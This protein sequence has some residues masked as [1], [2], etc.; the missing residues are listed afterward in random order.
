MQYFSGMLDNQAVHLGDT[1]CIQLGYGNYT[2]EGIEA[3][4]GQHVVPSLDNVYKITASPL[5]IIHYE[6]EDC[7]ALSQISTEKYKSL[8][9]EAYSEATFSE[10]LDEYQYP[11]L[12]AEYRSKKLLEALR[13]WIPVYK[14]KEDVATKVDFT[15]IGSAVADTGSRFITTPFVFGAVTFKHTSGCF[16]ADGKAAAKFAYQR[17]A[18]KFPD[19]NLNLSGLESTVAYTKLN[20]EYIFNTEKVKSFEVVK[21]F[22]SLQDAQDFIKGV[23]SYIINI[24]SDAITGVGMRPNT[25]AVTIKDVGEALGAARQLEV[26][27]AG[28]VGRK[29]VISRL[30]R[31]LT[32]LE[33]DL[34]A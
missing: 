2:I 26:K 16:K 14:K 34:N 21:T 7:G 20:G 23:E 17:M 28:E 6:K 25:L 27:R 3:P 4:G 15:V 33:A 19:S 8:R 1:Y 11:D 31:L 5:E 9:E 10:D 22:T 29:A 12:D 30:E 18:R 24:I 32:K 13:L